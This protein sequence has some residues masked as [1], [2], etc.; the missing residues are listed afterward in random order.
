MALAEGGLLVSAVTAFEFV[1][2]E[3][4]GRFPPGVVFDDLVRRFALTVV[5]FPSAAWTLVR[6]LPDIH[7]DPADRMLIAHAIHDSHTLVSA[8]ANIRRYPVKTLW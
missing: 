6:T 1:D 5:D 8:D 4:S 7:R 3:L 2:L